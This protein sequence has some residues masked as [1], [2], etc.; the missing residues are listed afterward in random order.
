MSEAPACVMPAW[1]AC[2]VLHAHHDCCW[3]SCL[4][5]ERTE[6]QC[7]IRGYIVVDQ[8]AGS[9]PACVAGP[10]V[11]SGCRLFSPPS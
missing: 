2:P 4:L 1:H 6:L 5:R 9:S 7:V 10:P 11:P 8:R 3:M